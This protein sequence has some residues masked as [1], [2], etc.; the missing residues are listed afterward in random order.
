MLRTGAR[1]GNAENRPLNA[2]PEQMRIPVIRI[3]IAA[4]PLL[5]A[6]VT[7]V[8]AQ[9]PAKPPSGQNPASSQQPA[10]KPD[11][12]A[13]PEDTTS[14]PVIPAA[15]TPA[16]VENGAD[17]ANTSAFPAADRDPARSPEDPAEEASGSNSESSSSFSGMDRLLP[18]PDADKNV[19]PK[20]QPTQQESAAQ[21]IE[22]GSYY[23]DRKNWKAALSRYQSALVLDPENPEVYWGLG[24]AARHLGDYANARSY[25][26]LLLDYDPDGPHGKQA[27]KLLKDPTLA[28]VGLPVAAHN[29]DAPK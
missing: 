24:E 26:R 28:D 2:L 22:V 20:K 21:N 23:L 14:V 18:A 7:A 4:L 9:S 6:A 10:P 3:Q 16:M 8:P 12:N 17:A 27:R 11:P 25:Y 15:A 19:K 29:A 1:S 5:L 13:F